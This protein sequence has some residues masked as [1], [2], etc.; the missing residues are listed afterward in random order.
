[1]F[2][3][4][5]TKPRDCGC[6]SSSDSSFWRGISKRKERSFRSFEK[7]SWSQGNGD[8]REGGDSGFKCEFPSGEEIRRPEAAAAVV[9]AAFA[10]GFIV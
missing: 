8:C 3:F 1:M 4:G 6:K 9:E 5:C 2:V 7:E 10:G